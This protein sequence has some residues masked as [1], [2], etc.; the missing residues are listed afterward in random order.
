MFNSSGQAV[1]HREG[2]CVWAEALV[3]HPLSPC[4]STDSRRKK[5]W[6]TVWKPNYCC[7]RPRREVRFL[8]KK[9]K[10]G[11]L[12]WKLKGVCPFLTSGYII[13]IMCIHHCWWLENGAAKLSASRCIYF[14]LSNVRCFYSNLCP[15]ARTVLSNGGGGEVRW[16]H[17]W[18]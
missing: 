15:N 12:L 9:K 18:R 13:L 14:W 5:M 16:K 8:G 17:F 7:C 11:L 3:K 2:Q 4:S 6:N 10:S 1:W